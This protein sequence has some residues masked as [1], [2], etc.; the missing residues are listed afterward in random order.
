MGRRL[1]WERVRLRDRLG[2]Q[3]RAED[4]PERFYETPTPRGRLEPER[5]ARILSL[6]QEKRE[7]ALG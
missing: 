1:Y 3:A 5:V 7:A 2:F 6:Y 4:V